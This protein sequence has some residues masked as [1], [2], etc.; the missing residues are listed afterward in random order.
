MTTS[1]TNK[2]FVCE[3]IGSALQC[4]K[5][6]KEPKAG[7]FLLKPCERKLSRDLAVVS[8]VGVGA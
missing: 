2:E 4:F 8:H 6:A 1:R 5:K 7:I 3:L